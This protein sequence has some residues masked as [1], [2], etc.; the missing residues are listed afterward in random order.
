MAENRFWISAQASVVAYSGASPQACPGLFMACGSRLIG[1]ASLG[2]DVSIWFNAIVRADVNTITIGDAC[3]I[4]D[5]AIIHCTYQ[6]FATDIGHRV[7][8]GHAA[9]VHGCTIE[10]DVLVGM[11]ATIMDGAVVGAGS[12][13]GAHALV[14][15]GQQI[16]PRSLV[17]GAPARCVRELT[18]QEL[19]SFGDTHKRYLRY[20]E[21]YST[22][23]DAVPACLV[24]NRAGSLHGDEE[25]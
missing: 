10:D 18:D 2:Y 12:V 3:N 8:I 23:L 15:Q 4:Q 17:M 13:V 14:T 5:S 24:I 9:V 16:P 11:G 7:S 22:Y 1:A 25:N 21:G 6:K 20:R 19:Q